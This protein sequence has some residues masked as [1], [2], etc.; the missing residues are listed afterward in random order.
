M[1]VP[2]LFA[3]LLSPMQP[4]SGCAQGGF[5]GC[6]PSLDGEMESSRALG[7]HL[8]PVLTWRGE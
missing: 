6:G 4:S 7:T 3:L 1:R 5:P 8:P 2:V